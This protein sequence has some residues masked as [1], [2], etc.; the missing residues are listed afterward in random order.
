MQDDLGQ[1]DRGGRSRQHRLF[2]RRHAGGRRSARGIAGASTRDPGN[3]GPM[4]CRLT[5]FEG[6]ERDIAPSRLTLSEDPKIFA[7]AGVVLVTVKSADTAEIADV[8]R[9]AC[10][11]RCRHRQFA[12]RCRQYVGAARAIARTARAGGHGA[13]QCG[14]FRCGAISSRHIGRHRYRAGRRRHR[15]AAFGA[16]VENARDRRH[17]RRAMGQAAGQSQ[18][19]AQRPGR[20][21]AAPA[22]RAARLAPAV[23]RPDRRRTDGAQGGGHPAGVADADSDGL[24]AAS[25]AAARCRYSPCCWGGP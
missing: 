5:S 13:V 12:E 11:C 24:A 20:S 25:A 2:C 10:A 19:R 4:G 7:D 15:G 18:Q 14:R 17:R 3:S 8:D 23:R 21:A 16:R 6:F 9:A 1:A 22:T